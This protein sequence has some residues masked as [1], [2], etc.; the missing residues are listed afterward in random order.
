MDAFCTSSYWRL[1]GFGKAMCKND[2]LRENANGHRIRQ[3]SRN[4]MVSSARQLYGDVVD[5]NSLKPSFLICDH[6]C[7]SLETE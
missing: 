3:V 6:S 1:K 2:T 4:V 5:P 7:M